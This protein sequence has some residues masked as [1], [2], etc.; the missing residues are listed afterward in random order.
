MPYQW[1]HDSI[2]STYTVN[3]I[4]TVTAWTSGGSIQVPVVVKLVLSFLVTGYGGTPNLDTINTNMSWSSSNIFT[5]GLQYQGGVWQ[6]LHNTTATNVFAFDTF[7]RVYNTYESLSFLAQIKTSLYNVAGPELSMGLA[8]NMAQLQTGGAGT[9]FLR[10][11]GGWTTATNSQTNNP[12]YG[13]NIGAFT[14]SWNSDSAFYQA[15]YQATKISGDNQTA[16]VVTT[17]P[18][19]LILKITDSNGQPVS[20]L[21]VTFAVTH[22]G[23][24]LSAYNLYTDQNGLAQVTWTLGPPMGNQNVSVKVV[25]GYNHPLLNS[26]AVFNATG[27]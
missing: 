7:S 21:P 13:K 20:N 12:V 26:P 17:L 2:L 5:A 27:Q 16:N 25:D 22:G 11:T 3:S 15:P 4:P 23:G 18:Q 1:T 19:P 6:A 8:G 10:K 9:P 24:T 14:Q